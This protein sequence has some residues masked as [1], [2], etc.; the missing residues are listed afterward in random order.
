MESS[1][2]MYFWLKGLQEGF[3]KHQTKEIAQQWK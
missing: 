3:N 2:S 1:Q